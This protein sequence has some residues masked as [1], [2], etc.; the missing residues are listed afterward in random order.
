MPQ[1]SDL[2]DQPTVRNVAACEACD[3]TDFAEFFRAPDRFLQASDKVHRVIQCGTCGMARLDRAR[4]AGDEALA[5]PDAPLWW[6]GV[7]AY[8]GR[9]AAGLRRIAMR[10]QMLFVEQSIRSDR[11]VLDISGAGGVIAAALRRRGIDVRAGEWGQEAAAR[12]RRE[13]SVPCARLQLPDACFREGSFSAITA[14]HVLEHLRDPQRTLK[15][16][17][18]LLA[19]GG[20]LVLQAPNP[21]SWQ[22]LLLADRWTGFDVPRHPL[23]LRISDIEELLAD[24]KYKVLRKKHF[25]LRDDPHSLATSLC[26]GLDPTLRAMHGI[27]ESNLAAGAKGALYFALSL[28][29][30][31]LTVLE[32]ASGAGASVLIEASPA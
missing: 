32:A 14:F 21:D 12:M 17:R 23:L 6:E 1:S 5:E 9:F 11:P 13:R 31:P 28:A 16:L 2:P 8:P 25:S 26:P 15:A 10:R 19:D 3:S 30:L 27:E 7:E 22:A 18:E 4:G 20:S 24:C 29:V